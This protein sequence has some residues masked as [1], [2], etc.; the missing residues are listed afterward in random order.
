M[1]LN[2]NIECYAV[3][4]YFAA[5]NGEVDK[6]GTSYDSNS[7]IK[8]DASVEYLVFEAQQYLNYM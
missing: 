8:A 4:T 6:N 7:V 5:N 1:V 3:I 2:H